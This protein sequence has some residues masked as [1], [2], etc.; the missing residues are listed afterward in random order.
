MV[1]HRLEWHPGV[2]LQWSDKAEDIPDRLLPGHLTDGLPRRWRGTTLHLQAQDG[3]GNWSATAHLP[4]VVDN[5][6]PAIGTPTPASGKLV[7]RQTL[8]LEDRG[9]AGIDPASLS[10]TVNG[11]AFPLAEF[12]TTTT[13]TRS[14]LLG[15]RRHRALLEP[16]P[17]GQPVEMTLAPV[18]DF[19]GNALTAATT[20]RYTVDRAG[21]TEPPCAPELQ[22]EG[23]PVVC[24]DSFTRDRQV[25]PQSGGIT[26]IERFLIPSAATCAPVSPPWQIT[27]AIGH[28]PRRLMSR[29]TPSSPLSIGARQTCACTL[30]AGQ[31]HLL[32][33]SAQR[34]QPQLP[35]PRGARLHRR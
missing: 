33:H 18:K 1:G 30:G 4:F 10:M 35:E 26:G 34:Q 22:V 9:P 13:T 17:D 16:I 32:R 23:A 12:V 7:S 28:A 19:A 27:W 29:S 15:G 3:A 6:P 20:F 2:S 11:K 31:W 24:L 25:A 14:A 5:T 8:P 21:D